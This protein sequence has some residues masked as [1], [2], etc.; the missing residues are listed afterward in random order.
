MTGGY[1]AHSFV[2]RCISM[3]VECVG[4]NTISQRL[5]D[6]LVNCPTQPTCLAHFDLCICQNKS[7]VRNMKCISKRLDWLQ[8][9]L[10]IVYCCR[11]S[12]QGFVEELPRMREN[13]TQHACARPPVSGVKEEF[14]YPLIC[15]YFCR[16]SLSL[17]ECSLGNIGP[18]LT[19]LRPSSQEQQHGL[20][21]PPSHTKQKMQFSPL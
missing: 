13:R 18:P 20:T 19:L 9:P 2:T 6:Q 7:N 3:P 17:E 12:E 16:L 14:K 4:C 21:S 10:A 15:V 11:Y 8:T 5:D 1:P